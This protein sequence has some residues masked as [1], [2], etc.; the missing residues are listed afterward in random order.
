MSIQTTTGLAALDGMFAA[1]KEQKRAAFLP[2]YPIG[3]P[4]YQTSIEAIAAM[5]ELGVDG[6]EIGMS[7]S[8]PLADGP[9]IQAATQVALKNGIG[10]KDCIKAV[11]ELRE[12]GVTQP[13]LLMGYINPILTY[14]V[15]RFIRDA[16]AAG[17]AGVI[18]PDLPPEEAD[19]SIR[20]CQEA[21]IAHVFLLAPTSNAARIELVSGKASGFIYL[22]SLTGITGARAELSP[23]IPAFVARVR[24]KTTQPLVMGF[25]ISTPAHARMM[26]G[27]VD[28]FIVG[29]ALVKAGGQG[30][31]AVRALAGSLRAAL[32]QA[33]G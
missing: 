9:V 33:A 27:L 23:E 31:E 19:D 26:T 24:A 5:A 6:F 10:V 22:V 17:A 1:A 18:I 16:Q 12:R 32:D 2:Y 14:G 3:Y 29:S 13:M 4:D 30:V 21:G 25:G 8:D 28:G 11:G 20:A 7:F 15:E